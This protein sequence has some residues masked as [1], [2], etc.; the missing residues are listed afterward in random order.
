[1]GNLSGKPSNNRPTD[2]T[3]DKPAKAIED[4]EA[5]PSMN[6]HDFEDR[7][8]KLSWRVPTG[9]SSDQEPKMGARRVRVLPFDRTP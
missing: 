2:A 3:F 4:G 8:P 9:V 1:M 5:V 7:R 6:T